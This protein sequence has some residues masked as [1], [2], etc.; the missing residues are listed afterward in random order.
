VNYLILFCLLF[1]LASALNG[2]A[3]NKDNGPTELI[4]SVIV[5]G[6]YFFAFLGFIGMYMK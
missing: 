4:A 2:I 6:M 3:V 5:M 1:P